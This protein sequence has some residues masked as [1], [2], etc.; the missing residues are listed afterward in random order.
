MFQSY[1]RFTTATICM[2]AIAAAAALPATPTA[3]QAKKEVSIALFVAIQSNP[4]EQAIINAFQKV[5]KEDGAARFVVFDSDNSVQ[6]ELANCNDAIAAKRFEAFALKPVAG[7]PLMA[8][9]K[10]ALEAGIPVVAFGNALGPDPHTEMR[11]VEGLSGS[12]VE[13]AKTNG[14]A[15]AEL[16][17]MACKARGANPCNVIYEYGP[18][19]FDWASISRK[20]FTETTEAKYKNIKIIA[21]GAYNFDPNQAR[22]LTK[23]LVQVHQNVD[24]I[25]SDGDLGAIGVVQ[26]LK[27]VG[28]VPGKDI[29][30]TG[31]A[32][33]NQGKELMAKGEMFGSTCLMPI[34]EAEVTARYSIQAARGEKIEKP[35]IEVCREFAKTGVAPITKEN[36]GDFTP[37]W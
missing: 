13:L 36:M 11:Q 12:V 2:A 24:V 31:G 25:A 5:A 33:S 9:A 3:A 27:D 4:V 20:F 23:S 15:L 19:A 30:V 1:K 7:P 22:T 29:F 18:L 34:T 21:S 16:V 6:K 26:G 32:I 17:D 28:K 10:K 8:C 35:D 14:E 37:E